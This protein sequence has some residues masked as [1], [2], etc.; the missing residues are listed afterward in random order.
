VANDDNPNWVRYAIEHTVDISPDND[1]VGWL[2]GY[3]NTQVIHHLFPS[4]PQFR[5]KEVSK[6]LE[7]FCKKWKIHYNKISYYQAWCN[8]FTNLN[9]VGE[10]M[11]A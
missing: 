10:K 1:F 4:M 3:L 6:E 5:G 11:A 7:V 9:M 2:M 8:M